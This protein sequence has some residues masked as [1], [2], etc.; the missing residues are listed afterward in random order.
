MSTVE[1]A[2]VEEKV[3]SSD[4]AD[5]ALRVW[6]KLFRPRLVRREAAIGEKRVDSAIGDQCRECESRQK[7]EGGQGGLRSQGGLRDTIIAVIATGR[8]HS[9]TDV[10]SFAALRLRV[11]L[12]PTCRSTSSVAR[13]QLQP[14]SL[15]RPS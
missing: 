15:S 8:G 14:V 6:L 7:W 4:S 13:R 11:E 3:R 9:D 12:K 2:I 1:R 5:Y 10:C